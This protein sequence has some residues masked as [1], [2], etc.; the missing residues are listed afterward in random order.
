M[1]CKM[2]EISPSG[3][4]CTVKEIYSIGIQRNAHWWNGECENGDG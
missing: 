1:E 3:G 4:T 2:E